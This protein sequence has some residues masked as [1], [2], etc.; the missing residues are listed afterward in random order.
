MNDEGRFLVDVGIRDVR[1]PVNVPSRNTP[2][3]QSTIGAAT[4]HARVNRDFEAAWIDQFIQILHRGKR[5]VGV[6]NMRSI[7]HDCKEAFQAEFVQIEIDY[8]V[9]V[10][11]KT[12]VSGKLCTV[13]Y[14][15]GYS[16]LFPAVNTTTT[17]MFRIKIPCITTY[18]ITDTEEGGL[19]AQLSIVSIQTQS[20]SDVFPEDL[21]SIVDTHALA[22][23]YSFL[24]VDD[25]KEI[26]ARIHSSKKTS[27]M[28]IDEIKQDLSLNQRI[29]FYTVSC[30]NFG[31][32]HSYST[33]IGVEK[34]WSP[35]DFVRDP[36]S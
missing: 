23:I 19:L 21:V 6:D 13:E 36:E 11:K 1:L 26:I 4:V 32:L 5:E 7:V 2:G 25:Q 9:F 30:S 20:T 33:L 8:P 22:P 16:A 15:C 3:G 14:R 28:M 35:W 31:L 12:P 34:S 17:I 24:S 18:P 29:D 10:E 27:V